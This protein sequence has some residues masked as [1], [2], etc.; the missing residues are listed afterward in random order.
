MALIE[1]RSL[2]TKTGTIQF[3]AYCPVTTFGNRYPLDQLIRPYLP[4]LAPAVMVSYYYA[5]FMSINERLPMPMMVDS[6]G[7]AVLFEGSKIRK[8]NGLGT[9]IIER[10]DERETLTP[11]KILRFQERIAD[12]AF[13][14]DFPIP[15]GLPQKEGSRRQ[16][17]TISNALWAL[18]NR[19]QNNMKLYGCIQAWD[20]TSAENNANAYRNSNFDGVAIGGLVPRAKN[21][22]L[23]EGIVKSVRK[24]CPHQPLHVFG[25]GKPETAKWLFEMGVDSVDSS[26]YVQA[27]AA[28]KVWGQE[29]SIKHPTTF[30][31]SH[32]ALNNLCIALGKKVPPQLAWQLE[33]VV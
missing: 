11:H 32:I 5:Q 7:F 13:T 25:L 6:G 4:R 33:Q 26:S 28:G 21:K 23:I 29:A 8:R 3:P 16:E 17:L 12:I 24:A 14:L 27:A 2:L 20:E 22:E 9:L 19:K 1:Q 18:D 10:E 30:E 15:P 31:R